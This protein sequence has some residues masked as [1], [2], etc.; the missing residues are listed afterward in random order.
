M[1][2]LAS[3]PS[4]RPPLPQRRFASSSVERTIATVTSRLQSLDRPDIATLFANCYPNTLDTTVA[5]HVPSSEAVVE[6]DG[7]KRPD[8]F[9][10]TGDIPAM[11]L[12]DSM[13]QVAP[14]MALIKEDDALRELVLGLIY[15]QAKCILSHPYSNAFRRTLCDPWD[16]SSDKVTPPIPSTSAIWESKYELD[17]LCAFL[18]LSTSYH[19]RAGSA[20]FVSDRQWL[21]ALKLTLATMRK[22]QKTTPMDGE[23]EY[24]FRR[25]SD[26]PSDTLTLGGR[27][28]PGRRCGMVRTAF[29][30]SDDAAV[31][32]FHLP[33]NCMAAVEL[34]RCAALLFA[35][36]R[37]AEQMSLAEECK[38]LA[39]EIQEGIERWGVV[40]HPTLGRVYAYEVDGRGGHLLMDDANVP[41]LLSLPYLG[42][43][44]ADDP[45]YLAT[46]AM[47]LSGDHNAFY[48]SGSAGTGV[49]SPHT[50]LGWIWP[51][52]MIVQG[53]TAVE[54]KERWECLE[55]LVC[56]AREEGFMHE[57][58]WMD[59]ARK[60]TR[61]WFAWANALFGELVI[62]VVGTGEVGLMLG[63]VIKQ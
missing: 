23:V 24:T 31:F 8:S 63:E 60:F 34:R 19:S 38:A 36:V 44:S 10:I 15:R 53:L 14:Y 13:N 27:G 21:A 25:A 22:Q 56:A 7:R 33:S 20:P 35:D 58:F 55:M 52:G 4:R 51:M 16:W 47:V 43:C 6:L 50:G 30:P 3:P 11:W 45:L 46:R 28:P 29:R 17:S 5:S 2:K 41:S 32:P 48:F 9:I 57:S 18:K 54:E 26:V 40:T 12:R 37:N 42:F 39:G 62:K 59:D 49:G 61:A 1:S